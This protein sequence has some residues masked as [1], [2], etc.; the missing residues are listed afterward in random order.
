MILPGPYQRKTYWPVQVVSPLRFADQPFLID[1]ALTE[2]RDDEACLAG[3]I[4]V[5]AEE[6]NI[7]LDPNRLVL[8][9][10]RW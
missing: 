10:L 3:S 4:E 6:V 7:R 2:L 1:Y 5:F 9:G 8:R